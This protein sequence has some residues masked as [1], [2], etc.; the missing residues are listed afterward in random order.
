MSRRRLLFRYEPE[1]SHLV[2]QSSTRGCRRMRAAV[3]EHCRTQASSSELETLPTDQ[4]EELAVV[5]AETAEG[6]LRV[7]GV[8][9]ALVDQAGEDRAKLR[10]DPVD[11]LVTAPDASCVVGDHATGR[12]VAPKQLELAGGDVL[13][14]PP[15]DREGLRDDVCRIFGRSRPSQGVCDD[16]GRTDSYSARKRSSRAS[17]LTRLDPLQSAQS[18][19]VVAALGVSSL[20]V[21]RDSRAH[22]RRASRAGIVGSRQ[23]PRRRCWPAEIRC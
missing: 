19:Y 18:V 6:G 4:H 11:Q 23:S 21:C 8:G 5:V 3:G 10:S 1:L 20:R 17:V 2:S 13:E 16:A 12:R 15:D 22:R 7:Q 9:V 14:P